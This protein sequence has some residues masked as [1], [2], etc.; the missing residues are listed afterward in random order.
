[1]ESQI[2]NTDLEELERIEKTPH[3]DI[4]VDQWEGALEKSKFFP[5]NQDYFPRSGNSSKKAL[6][7]LD[8]KNMVQENANVRQSSKRMYSSFHASGSS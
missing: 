1:M 5:L 4:Q 2:S 8:L 3:N 6:L 7:N